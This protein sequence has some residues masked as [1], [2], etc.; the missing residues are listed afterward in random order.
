VTGVRRVA[1]WDWQRILGVKETIHVTASPSGY[2]VEPQLPICRRERA[3]VEAVCAPMPYS[4]CE[5][6]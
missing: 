3:V 2:C 6:P 4:C 5:V 1:A